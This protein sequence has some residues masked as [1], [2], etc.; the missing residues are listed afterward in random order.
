MKK[1]INYVSLKTPRMFSD[2][3]PEEKLKKAVKISDLKNLGPS[4]EKAFAN[5][6]VKTAQQ[7][8]KL[9]WKKTYEKLVISNHKN[10][11]TIFAYAL[12][13]A[14][15]NTEWNRITPEEKQAAKDETLKLKKKYKKN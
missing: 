7:F 6:G 12:I 2:E 1:K 3:L 4:S 15:T 13:G 8:I 14:L 5:A 9:G 10:L 11:H